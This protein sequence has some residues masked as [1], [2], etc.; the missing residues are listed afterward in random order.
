[1]AQPR[2]SVICIFYQ[3]ERFFSEAVDSVLGQDF[4]DFEL[5]LC[6][7]GS[8][9]GGTALAKDYAA[10]H[11]GK[12]R[13]LEHPGHANRGMSA[14][15]NL[16]LAHARGELIAFIDADDRWR[17]AKLREQVAILDA[18]PAVGM[19]CGAVNYWRS[20]QGGEDKPTTTGHAADAV[21]APPETSLQLYP[22]GGA[23]ARRRPT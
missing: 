5:L 7:Y 23:S 4:A 2:V 8:S 10:R 22:L 14:T 19:V 12:V 13:Y 20:W 11:P 15:R 16:G 1:L 17:P 18:N 9:D 3:A 6:D 21:S